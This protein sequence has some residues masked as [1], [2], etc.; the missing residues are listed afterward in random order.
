MGTAEKI[1][2]LFS[3]GGT[4]GKTKAL[5]A[6]WEKS[7]DFSKGAKNL[8]KAASELADAAKSGDGAAVDVKV[9]ALSNACGSC[10]KAFRAEKYSGE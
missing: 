4:A 9:K 10:H 3:K 1:P 6:I 2:D 7:D 5:P 8:R